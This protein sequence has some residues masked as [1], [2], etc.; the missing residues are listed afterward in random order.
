MLVAHMRGLLE[1]DYKQGVRSMIR[2]ELILQA[3]SQEVEGHSLL[4]QAA[5]TSSMMPAIEEKSRPRSLRA[6]MDNLKL[7]TALLRLEPYSQLVKG[8]KSHSVEANIAA[9]KMLAHTDVF[10]ILK[11]SLEKDSR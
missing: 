11:Q 10:S 6:A 1:P 8:I 7:G 5:M 3:L 2:E 9:L 4:V